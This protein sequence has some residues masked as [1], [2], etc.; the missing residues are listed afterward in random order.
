MRADTVDFKGVFRVA[1][2]LVLASASPRR[3]DFLREL[4][5]ACRVVPPAGEAEPLPLPG[6][7]PEAF[8]ARAAKAK[9]DSVYAALVAENGGDAMLP[10]VLGADTVVFRNGRIYGKP[11]DEEEAFQFLSELAGKEH[12]VR[13]SCWLRLGPD[14]GTAFSGSAKV[15]MGTW[16]ESV[17][18]AYA[19]SGEGLDKA[20]GY[21]VQGQGAF[22]VERVAGS[23]SAVIGLPVAETVAALLRHG[24]IE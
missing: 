10:A 15:S 11:S 16:P 19:K 20:G 17:L 4:G 21:A 9:A 24:I 6:E 3:Q 7:T 18:R 8:V 22:L 1:R 14:A 23:W 13:T 2:P 5:I 12:T